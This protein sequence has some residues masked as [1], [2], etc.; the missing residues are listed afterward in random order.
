MIV[1][2]GRVS[3]PPPTSASTPRPSSSAWRAS[4][5]AWARLSLGR[6]PRGSRGSSTSR[7]AMSGA[8]PLASLPCFK[9]PFPLWPALHP[10]GRLHD[11]T[12]LPPLPSR[13]ARAS[14]SAPLSLGQASGLFRACD[15]HRCT[16]G[17]FLQR[18]LSP[19]QPAVEATKLA[20][21]RFSPPAPTEPQIAFPIAPPGTPARPTASGLFDAALRRR[22][23]TSHPL[24]PGSRRSAQSPLR[25]LTCIRPALTGVP[26]TSTRLRPALTRVPMTS[27]RLRL[28]STRVRSTLMR[29]CL[30]LTSHPLDLDAHP[31]DFD[32]HPLDFDAPPPGF[33][34]SRST[35]TSTA[36]SSAS[37]RVTMTWKRVTMTSTR[38]T[39]TS[40]RRPDSN[41]SGCHR[42]HPARKSRHPGCA[43]RRARCWIGGT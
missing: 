40:T 13:P 41:L 19:P 26:M 30:T 27:T 15:G 1:R 31:L 11:P 35:M 12:H 42:C 6:P 16:R 24:T 23:A 8:A 10:S 36:H 39:M 3:S 7:G 4:G 17:A 18:A 33:D 38:I 14:V 28:A 5:S 22:P 37:T 20:P 9:C 25:F 32:A 29:V 43:S 34:A 21:T 2:G